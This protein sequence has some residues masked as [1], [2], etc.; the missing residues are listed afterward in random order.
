ME[1][2]KVAVVGCGG[3]GYNHAR[4]YYENRLS[5]LCAVVGRT[6]ERTKA[7]AEQFHV[8]YYLDVEEM[9]AHEK[10]DF[11]SLCLPALDTFGTTMKVI[12]AG[13]PLLVEK[14][15]AYE[16]NEAETMIAEAEK[17]GL[18]M[19]IDF[20]QRFSI[21]A[22]LAKKASE[23]GKLGDLNYAVWRFGHGWA[24]KMAHPHAN[25]IEAQCH[26]MNFL[27]AFCGPI[28]S[29]MAEMT[30]K[31][32]KGGY[33][34]FIL[35]LRFKSGAL[36]SLISTVDASFDYPLCQTIEL[37]G[38]RGRVLIED[39][40]QKYTYQAIDSPLSESWSPAFFMDNERCFSR[41][42]DRL[43]DATLHA[44]LRGETPPTPAVE[45]LRALK[46]AYCAIESY[47]KGVRIT[48]PD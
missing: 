1:K 25:L 36:G 45:G 2:V 30:D 35:T 47:E 29:V 42:T 11:V 40:A 12:R 20:N 22:Q 34:T 19:G 39:N 6:E 26:G 38:S 28:E 46:L 18:F 33:S 32:G 16:L 44:F 43:I 3:W 15:L 10:P 21:P 14:P 13:V 24:P 48:V 7:R 8:P 17:R 4:A 9:L 41:N 23:E 37:N 27:E 31:S 5:T